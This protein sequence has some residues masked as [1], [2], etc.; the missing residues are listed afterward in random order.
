MMGAFGAGDEQ[1]SRPDGLGG[2][3]ARSAHRCRAWVISRGLTA[4]PVI[5]R[6]QSIFIDSFQQPAQGRCWNRRRRRRDPRPR[7]CGLPSP[8]PVKE[9]GGLRESG[10]LWRWMAERPEVFDLPGRRQPELPARHEAI[11]DRR[12]VAPVADGLRVKSHRREHPHLA[13]AWPLLVPAHRRRVPPGDV[14][15]DRQNSQCRSSGS[16]LAL[17]V[18]PEFLFPVAASRESS[19]RSFP[20]ARRAGRGRSPRWRRPRAGRI[21]LCF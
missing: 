20:P 7:S 14:A 9:F 16:W 2:S 11:D 5:D 4:G 15:R 8:S 13:L 3:P 19:S 12:G 21:R 1:I 17:S 6:K 10:C 18:P